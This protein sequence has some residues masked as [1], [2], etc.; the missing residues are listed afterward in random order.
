MRQ[1][2]RPSSLKNETLY[3]IVYKIAKNLFISRVWRLA[4]STGFF[5]NWLVFIFSATY[6]PDVSLYF[7]FPFLFFECCAMAPRNW[8]V[9]RAERQE[10]W[11]TSLKRHLYIESIDKTVQTAAYFWRS[12][13][14]RPL[15]DFFQTDLFSSFRR[16]INLTFLCIFC[17]FSLYPMLRRSAAGSGGSCTPKRRGR[18]V[19]MDISIWNCQWNL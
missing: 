1:D 14:Q 12:L 16:R 13:A 2:T 8:R 5:R 10:T 19:E 15:P 18:P 7:L 6:K 17:F 3:Q 11:E 4:P 9:L